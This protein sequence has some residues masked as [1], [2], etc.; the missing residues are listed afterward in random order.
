LSYGWQ[1]NGTSL[2]VDLANDAIT[3]M[4]PSVEGYY[5]VNITNAAGT[6]NITW[7][8]RLALP[9]M[10]EGWGSDSSHESD[11]PVSLTNA[12][13]IAA[14]E[15]QSVAVTDAGSVVQWGQY[16]N[17]T[18]AYSVSN[19]TVAT[20]PPTSGVMAVAAGLQQGLALMTNGTVY[21]WGLTSTYGVNLATNQYLTGVSAVACGWKFDLAL[22]TNGTVKA[23]GDNTFGQTNIPSNATNVMAIAAEANNAMVL[24][25]NGIIVIWGDSP[26]GNPTPPTTLT[27]PAAIA[28]GESHWL[29]LQSNGCVVAWGDNTYGQIKVPAAASNNVMAIAA[30]DN[31]SVALLNNGTLVEWGN[32]SSGQTNTPALQT[33]AEQIDYPT[34]PP[35]A[36]P[37]IVVKYISAAGNHTL[38]SIFS[39]GVQYPV[40]VA[41]DLLLIYNS[42]STNNTSVFQYYQTN[43]PGVSNALV[44]PIECLPNDPINQTAFVNTI[45]QPIQTWL[46]NNPTLRPSYVV[47]FQDI[48]G[49]IDLY[50]NSPASA[51]DGASPSVQYQ[52]HYSTAPGWSPFV[53]AIN[54]NG[55]N[56]T[57][58][59]SSDGTKD[60]IAYINK[61]TNMA[62]ASKTLFIS[63]PSTPYTN[64]NWYFDDANGAT[65][66]P[67]GLDAMY[68]VESN[69][70][71]SSAITYTPTNSATHITNAANVL[72]YFTWGGN[73]SL[74]G[75]YATNGTVLFTNASSW[76]LIATSESFNGQSVPAEA[77]G[78]FLDWFSSNAF[79]GINYSNTPVGAIT[80]VQEPQVIAN[81]TYLYFGNWAAGKSF[82]ISAW[83]GQIGTYGGTNTDL[84]F[85][86]VGDPFVKK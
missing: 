5:T 24:Q 72:G 78:N 55:T 62:G 27:N 44:L 77:Q 17:G 1:L 51:D 35:V 69:G 29:A 18:T 76:Y 81:N 50:T 39:P 26:L 43:R 48:A 58:F 67:N 11:R 36:N 68:G 3:N 47:L 64:V 30:G 6:T 83:A 32:D 60:C 65:G 52:L 21:P 53:T 66:F 42:N 59:Y 73:S 15:Y 45:Q 70:V 86:A 82:A 31:H 74:G 54:M 56:G 10:V 19:T 13:G 23:W 41:K 37:S 8:I 57:N 40:N 25:S 28:S 14:G 12:T 71:P 85:Q 84:Y 9:G 75:G 63:A 33:T 22:L 80:H 61:L 20:L 34:E 2:G 49:E 4:V 79:G 16:S 46:S 7:N 38:A